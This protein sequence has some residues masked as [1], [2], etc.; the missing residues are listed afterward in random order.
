MIFLFFYHKHLSV[1]LIFNAHLIYRH[2]DQLPHLYQTISA[3]VPQ[4]AM[5]IHLQSC[6]HYKICRYLA[7]TNYRHIF[8]TLGISI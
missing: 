4:L 8:R 7:T 1:Y 6:L 2:S 3:I 5:D